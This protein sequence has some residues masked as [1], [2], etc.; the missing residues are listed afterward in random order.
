MSM[1]SCAMDSSAA[2]S[3]ALAAATERPS[4]V[5]AAMVEWGTVPQTPIATTTSGSKVHECGSRAPGTRRAIEAHG[6]RRSHGSYLA[7]LRPIA[8]PRLAS[9]ATVNS[10]GTTTRRSWSRQ[11]RSG[12]SGL[13]MS[14]SSLVGGGVGRSGLSASL[15][16]LAGGE[17]ALVS[18]SGLSFASV[19]G[20]ASVARDRSRTQVARDNR[21]AAADLRCGRMAVM[22]W[23]CRKR[24][25]LR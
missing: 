24:R 9:S 14:S 15:S 16:S 17:V 18:S 4:A 5:S 22:A 11:Y 23:S 12:R 13:P 21:R 7:C 25:W 3:A 1:L 19:S 8:A 6:F 2:P 20:G 10:M